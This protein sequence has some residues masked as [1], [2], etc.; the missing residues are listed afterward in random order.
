MRT[1]ILLALISLSVFLFVTSVS[2]VIDLRVDGESYISQ[3]E[4]FRGEGSDAPRLFKPLYGVLGAL[5]SPVFSP[6]GAIVF[7]NL[8]FL[9]GL[10]GVTYFFLRE[11]SFAEWEARVG[12][13]WV[14][15]GYPLLK[16][17]LAIST[18]MGGWFFA[19]STILLVLVALRTESTRLLFLASLVGFLGGITKETGV[20]GLIAGGFLILF[21]FRDKPLSRVVKQIFILALPAL[22][23]EGALIAC[24]TYLG[25]PTFLDW[26]ESNTE[27][28]GGAYYTLS[29]WLFTEGGAFNLLWLFALCGVF[30][31]LKH[32]FMR[33]RAV[34]LKLVAIF[35][36]TLPILLW[37]IFISR[38]LFIQFL[39]VVPLAL[40]GLRFF[41]R[42]LPQPYRLLG[43][44]ILVAL[45]IIGSTALFLLSEGGSLYQTFGLS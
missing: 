43:T 9:C 1:A 22:I 42:V 7:L 4:F 40:L 20:L 34:I 41:S 38:I 23:L 13:L 17:G 39:F 3:V 18:D 44:S 5:L 28:Y 25:L 36:A 35:L 19:A 15:T 32:G 33:D 16:Y 14:G 27:G 30:F 26:Y 31:Y 11:L 24:L 29:Y 21:S 45:P 10:L 37:P 12:A 6:A 2:G 8:L